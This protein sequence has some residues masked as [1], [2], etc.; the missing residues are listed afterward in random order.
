MG[1]S[2][3]LSGTKS[4]TISTAQIQLALQLQE[5]HESLKLFLPELNWAAAGSATK[6]QPIRTKTLQLLWKGFPSM[7]TALSCIGSSTKSKN[8][9][10]NNELRSQTMLT[11]QTMLLK[12]N[13][14][15]N[16]FLILSPPPS[17]PPFPSLPFPPP[18]HSSSSS[19]WRYS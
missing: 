10:N 14:N 6:M 9:H 8:T 7:I 17:L 18:H 16:P 1:L 12:R 19:I 11:A 5:T 2:V 3:S 4:C 13:N 15:N